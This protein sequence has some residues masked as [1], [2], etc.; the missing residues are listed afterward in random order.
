M[1]S[2]NCLLSYSRDS[3]CVPRLSYVMLQYSTSACIEATRSPALIRTLPMKIWIE[4]MNDRLHPA[5]QARL[6]IHKF[7]YRA[8]SDAKEARGKLSLSLIRISQRNILEREN[9][10]FL[11]LIYNCSVKLL[12]YSV[13]LAYHN[14]REHAFN[15]VSSRLGGNIQHPSTERARIPFEPSNRA[16]LLAP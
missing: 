9:L 11:F 12:K 2:D 14:S 7:L 3:S 8:R 1:K 10:I 13:T 6:V 16:D 15:S 5:L 4:M